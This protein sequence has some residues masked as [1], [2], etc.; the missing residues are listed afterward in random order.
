[1]NFLETNTNS[2]RIDQDVLAFSIHK[3]D[4][5]VMEKMEWMIQAFD[6]WGEETDAAEGQQSA[7]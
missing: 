7:T 6:L 5:F 2:Y 1:M 3:D 4:D